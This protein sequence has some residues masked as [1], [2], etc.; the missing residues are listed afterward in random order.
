MEAFLLHFPNNN[1]QLLSV[2]IILYNQ[3]PL[4]IF[5]VSF[6]AYFLHMHFNLLKLKQKLKA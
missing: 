2:Y 4:A 3:E 6:F 5:I 1:K